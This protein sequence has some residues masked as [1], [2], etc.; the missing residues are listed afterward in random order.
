MVRVQPGI[1]PTY[2]P[3]PSVSLS[4]YDDSDR[5][6][7][8]HTGS[9]FVKARLIASRASYAYCGYHLST[10]STEYITYTDY[11]DSNGNY[12]LV[13]GSTYIPEATGAPAANQDHIIEVGYPIQVS[14]ST[15]YIYSPVFFD[16]Y[17]YFKVRYSH[18]G[19]DYF[20]TTVSS[21]SWVF[22]DTLKIRETEVIPTGQY[23]YSIN[24][25]SSVTAR[26]FRIDAYS[27]AI[28]SDSLGAG[29]TSITS[30]DT[31]DFPSTWTSM[32]DFYFYGTYA[33]PPPAGPNFLSS[34][35]YTGK[36]DT[37]FT[38]VTF[39]SGA[40]GSTVNAGG[41]VSTL[42]SFAGD[43]TEID[44]VG[45]SD[46]VLEF[47]DVGT[48]VAA[49]SKSLEKD[50]YYDI[51]YDKHDSVFFT[52]RY[53]TDLDGSAGPGFSN[54][55]NFDDSDSGFNTTR[56]SESSDAPNFQHN[57]TSGTVE[58]LNGSDD[59]SIRTNY[60]LYG[61]FASTIDVGFNGVSSSAGRVQ[62]RTIDD[63]YNNVFVQ[64]GFKGPFTSTDT[65]GK[66]EALQSRK[67]SDTT[68][69]YASVYNLRYDLKWL[70]DGVETFEF[71]YVSASDEWTVVSGT[72]LGSL[73]NV[74]PGTSYTSGPLSLSIVHSDDAVDGSQIVLTVNKQQN[75]LP[76]YGT[77]W[78]WKQ[79]IK[80]TGTDIICQYDIGAGL[81]DWVTFIDSDVK[82]LNLELYA[83][84]NN[85]SIDL[86]LDNFSVTGNSLFSS[87]PVFSLEAVNSVGNVVNVAGLTDS[88]GYIIKNWDIIN[89]DA[90]YNEFINKRVQLA[91]DGVGTGSVYLKLGTDLYKYNRSS[92]PIAADYGDNAVVIASGVVPEY[93]AEA[94]SYNSYSK[95][96]LCYIEYDDDRSGTYV[97][98][99]STTTLSGTEYESLLD[100]DSADKPWT[101]DINNYDTL[102]YIDGTSEKFYDLDEN[103]VAFC[104]VVSA[105]KIMSAGTS[106]T[107]SVTAS[108][109]NAYGEPMPSK[110]VSF[111]VTAGAGSLSP[112]SACT[113]SSGTASTVYTVGSEVGI[114]TIQASASDVAC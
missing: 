30:V 40:P 92:F 101:W 68:G 85:E 58:Y 75:S 72:S 78:W 7:F 64:M 86:S 31:T 23:K 55:D 35:T 3:D 54:G 48:G 2:T 21:V 17:E 5:T 82:N 91:N 109:L 76:A 33:S 104:N 1:M 10:T 50:Y 44:V 112:A 9:Q 89:R 108:V 73:D 90:S 20:D 95:A 57:T 63:D 79:G 32:G 25:S 29:A 16:F 59:A 96:G 61:D 84:G 69:G 12:V 67:T 41:T 24:L 38:G 83:D 87:F 11:V 53:N 100:A 18:N 4:G 99:V 65:S 110:T 111:V 15:I 74:T 81:I 22:D 77:Q 51:V 88:D 103:D 36:T 28:S 80:R 13:D 43:V 94:F 52:L 107:S 102:Y 19:S 37:S 8:L 14:T 26:Y 97:T 6:R 27:S 105:E 60:Y 113:T 66:W 93:T 98:T 47:W 71:T 34:F 45:I 62:L 39:E 56:W 106:T 46:P 114:S 42:F 49:A 70:P